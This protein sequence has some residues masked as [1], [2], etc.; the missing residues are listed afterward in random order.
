M[1]SNE[2]PAGYYLLTLTKRPCNVLIKT[3]HA[4]LASTTECKAAHKALVCLLLVARSGHV[5]LETALTIECGATLIAFVLVSTSVNNKVALERALAEEVFL[6]YGA[7]LWPFS[8]A[9]TYVFFQVAH[10]AERCTAHR[11]LGRLL[12]HDATTS[13]T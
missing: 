1:L 9:R 2:S 13:K 8:S 3:V 6:T 7:H 12:P 10:L 4:G 5:T 11:A